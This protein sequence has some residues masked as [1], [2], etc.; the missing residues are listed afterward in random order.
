MIAET[1]KI[2]IVTGLT[3]LQIIITLKMLSIIEQP[4]KNFAVLIKVLQLKIAIL[5]S[6]GDD[7][8]LLS[9]N[10]ILNKIIII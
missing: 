5:N 3:K 4:M 7:L 1:Q 8:S 10:N 9:M 6:P 2:I